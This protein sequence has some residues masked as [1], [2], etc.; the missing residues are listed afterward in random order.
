MSK[1]LPFNFNKFQ[2]SNQLPRGWADIIRDFALTHYKRKIIV[3]TSTTSREAELTLQ[4][5]VQIVGGITIRRTLPWLYD[6]YRGLFRDI[7][8]QCFDEEVFI[9]KDDRYAINLNIQQG[10][11]MRYECHVDS[12]PIEGL[13]YVTTHYEGEGGELVVSH[14]PNAL[15]PSEIEK[16]CARFYPQKGDLLFF[17]ARDYPHYVTPLTFPGAYRIVVAMNFYTPS[18]TE[19]MRPSDLN[20]HLGIE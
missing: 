4:L 5:P 3:P 2:V 13:L 15:G 14:D 7:A 20:K 16:N 8:A 10:T 12:N 6:I 1:I 11:E 19:E 9:A 18:C 17:D